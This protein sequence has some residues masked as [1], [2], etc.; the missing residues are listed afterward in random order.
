MQ[1]HKYREI[2]LKNYSIFHH[3]NKLK[4]KQYDHKI[5][6]KHEKMSHLP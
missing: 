1:E 4:E 3:R 5:Q 6:E 2:F